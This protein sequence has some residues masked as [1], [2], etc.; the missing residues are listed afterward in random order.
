VLDWSDEHKM[1]QDAIRDFVQKEIVPVHQQPRVRDL[2]PY[3]VLRKLFAA[4][5]ID[6][7]ARASF[8]ERLDR[9][10]SQSTSSTAGPAES[11]ASGFDPALMLILIKELA[12]YCPGMVTALGVSVGLTASAIDSQG[13]PRQRE[14]WVPDLLDLDSIGAWA[15]TE[16]G[17]APTHS[18]PCARRPA[19]TATAT[20]SDSHGLGPAT[21]DENGACLAKLGSPWCG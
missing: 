1:L 14:R 12:R 16:P 3:D 18:V 8:N 10:A 2:A 17:A 9:A 19:G 15:L 5:G 7:T 21:M 11:S 20:F 6:A 13:T 4:F